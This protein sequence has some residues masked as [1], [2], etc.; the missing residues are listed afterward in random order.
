MHS[1]LENQQ[2]MPEQS[3]TDTAAS[4]PSMVAST[5]YHSRGQHHAP[6][7]R[8]G[9]LASNVAVFINASRADGWRRLVAV[10]VLPPSLQ[11]GG[12]CSW[13]TRWPKGHHGALELCLEIWGTDSTS[14]IKGNPCCVECMAA[15]RDLFMWMLHRR[16]S[17]SHVLKQDHV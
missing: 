15:R 3:K 9:S 2:P 17:D 8:M 4:M 5:G 10:P 6:Q 1:C 7:R 14:I 11:Q 13:C 12:L 16:A